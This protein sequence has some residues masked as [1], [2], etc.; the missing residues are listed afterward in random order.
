MSAADWPRFVEKADR[1]YED[2]V[3]N[4]THYFTEDGD[5]LCDFDVHYVFYSTYG[6][7]HEVNTTYGSRIHAE[8]VP[9]IHAERASGRLFTKE[10]WMAFRDQDNLQ[11]S[12]AGYRKLFLFQDRFYIQLILKENRYED[13]E[14]GTLVQRNAFEVALYGWT[15]KEKMYVQPLNRS[16]IAEDMWMPERDWKAEG[17]TTEDT[18]TLFL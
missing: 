18:P 13:A 4:Y 5:R 12:H 17:R 2:M 11:E 16:V 7:H 14:T 6:I 1:L 9:W 8:I 10:N 15:D 3:A